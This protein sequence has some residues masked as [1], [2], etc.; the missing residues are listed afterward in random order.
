MK[1]VLA[2]LFLSLPLLASLVAPGL[3]AGSTEPLPVTQLNQTAIRR[4]SDPWATSAATVWGENWAYASARIIDGEYWET[5]GSLWLLPTGQGEG[6]LID[7]CSW[8]M[9]DWT[10]EA[11]IN[12]PDMAD[13]T[14]V[15]SEK[16][17]SDGDCDIYGYDMASQTLFPVCT[18]TG[19]QT[20]PRVS[21]DLVVWAD[22]RGASTGWDIYGFDLN[23][24]TE[25]PICSLPSQQTDPDVSGTTVVWVDTR[26]GDEDIY[27]ATVD[28]ARRAA[29]GLAICSHAGAQTRPRIGDS[30]VVWTDARDA[31][32]HIY[33]K[34]LQGGGVQLL[35][36]LTG[37]Q[38][39]P[40]V[41]GD[42]VLWFHRDW[43]PKSWDCR[44]AGVNL[45]TGR[46]FTTTVLGDP[47]Y[48]LWLYAVDGP[49]FSWGFGDRH[50]SM[51]HLCEL[52]WQSSIAIA[53]GKTWVT[54]SVLPLALSAETAWSVVTS[55]RFSNDGAHWTSFQPYGPSMSYALPPGEGLRTVFAQFKGDDG[56]VSPVISD[57]VGLDTEAPLSRDDADGSWHA[58]EV[59][60][61]FQSVDATSGVAATKY[62][63]DG[64]S[65]T[66]GSQAV[67]PAP[68]DHS[69]D[70]THRIDYRSSDVAGN[71]ESVRSC[72]VKIDTAGPVTTCDAPAAWVNH[73]VAVSFIARD[74]GVGVDHIEF[75]LDGGGWTPAGGAT[76]Y[77][78]GVH[79]LALRA[80]DLLGNVG[81]TKTYTVRI[82]TLGPTTAAL[83]KASVRRGRTA[84]LRYRVDDQQ[85]CAG[86]AKVTIKVMT[87][88][89][90]VVKVLKLGKRAV[91]RRLSYRF[92]CTLVKKTYRFRVYAT[93]AAGNKQAVIGS[94]RLVVH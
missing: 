6:A 35:S 45:A 32:T 8:P 55:A 87:L 90:R 26:N 10:M 79:T 81:A 73:P 30:Q 82:D 1:R 52:G 5:V 57:D 40:V 85:P 74:A 68:A 78:D 41:G 38:I 34:D 18:A 16:H 53:D 72:A 3:A 69:F 61:H 63:L 64:G 28:L 4:E 22:N 9:A 66:E 59:T 21:G 27:G 92:R 20:S 58:S 83:A 89:G 44:I 12:S 84:T 31:E 93:D 47:D 19:D 49:R 94:N 56:R 17:D 75:D 2:F 51:V 77:Y 70:G 33:G 24:K 88:R 71:V 67:V 54:S 23:T 86:K 15:W 62:R 80:L 7:S 37:E 36:G 14:L 29:S 25:F 42:E 48:E 46:R 91:N 39:E 65:W 11:P 60:V 13:G 43:Q 76:V 50:G